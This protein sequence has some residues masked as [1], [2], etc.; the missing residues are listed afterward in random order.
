MIWWHYVNTGSDNGLLPD[1]KKLLSEPVL[2]KITGI[3]FGQ[4]LC[5][6]NLLY[7]SGKKISAENSPQATCLIKSWAVLATNRCVGI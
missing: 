2:T 1:S 6:D 4:V 5:D 3:L 7:I